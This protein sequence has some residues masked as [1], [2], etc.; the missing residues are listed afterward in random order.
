MANGDD[1][2]QWAKQAAKALFG[3]ERTHE[4]PPRILQ[5]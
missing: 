2:D 3:G 4:P 5:I 1:Q